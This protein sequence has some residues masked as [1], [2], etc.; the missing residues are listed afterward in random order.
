[1]TPNISASLTI[2]E[3]PDGSGKSTAAKAYAELTG[4]KYV[5]F[6]ALPRVSRGLAR[7]Y[8]EAMLPALLGYQ[9]VVFDR[10]WLSE[11]PYG[12]A[13]REGYDRMT[14]ADRRMLERLSMRCGGVVVKCLPPFDDVK[15]TYLSRKHMEMLDNDQQLKTV[16]DLYVKQNTDLPVYDYDYTMNPAGIKPDDLTGLRMILHPTGMASAGNLSPRSIVLVGDSFAERKDNDPYYQWPFASFSNEGCSRW[17]T[18]QLDIIDVRENELFWINA[19]QD[20]STLNSFLRQPAIALGAEAWQKLERL[21]IDSI[22]IS[23][24]Q[25]HKRFASK[26]YY[27]LV[28]IISKIKT[29][30]L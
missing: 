18:D 30:T 14:R 24:P 19:D 13:F 9:S 17:L 3:G 8:V 6:P 20:L 29:G 11:L 4:A 7:M 15:R 1:M 5:H 21:E 26:E 25:Y 16:Y 27:P 23:H 10:C 2:F 22:G 12:V 28:N